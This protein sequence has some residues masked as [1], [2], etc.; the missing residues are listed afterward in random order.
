MQKKIIYLDYLEDHIKIKNGG[1]L[2]L[3]EKDDKVCVRLQVRGLYPTDTLDCVMPEGETLHLEKGCGIYQREYS[4]WEI[5]DWYYQGRLLI[6]IPGG[7]CLQAGWE[8]FR[9]RPQMRTQQEAMLQAAEAFAP[10]NS[11]AAIADPAKRKEQ[12]NPKPLPEPEGAQRPEMPAEAEPERAQRPEMPAEAEPE[13][14]PVPEMPAEPEGTEVPAGPQEQD[15][16]IQVYYED[17]WEQLCHKFTQIHPFGDDREYL[18]ITPADFIIFPKQYQKLV[19]NSF[20]LHG[21]YNYQHLILGKIYRNR[22]TVYYLGTPGVY[23]EREKMAAEMF[24]F[25]AFEYAGEKI[26]DGMFGYYMRRVEI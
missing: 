6:R 3:E 18:S 9:D 10:E 20:L 4:L 16:S 23:Y 17:K 5:P 26:E 22:Q 7:R 24:G 8:P 2:R 25:E 14:I 19:H 1:F 12:A 11:A 13:N 21:F 15:P